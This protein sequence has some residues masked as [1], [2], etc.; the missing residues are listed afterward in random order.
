M[1]FDVFRLPWTDLFLAQCDVVKSMLE[2]SDRVCLIVSFLIV[3]IIE[4]VH[5]VLTILCLKLVEEDILVSLFSRCL[6]WK[7]LLIV[8]HGSSIFVWTYESG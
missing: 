8:W 1:A 4:R 2:P 6:R 3:V 5:M 7:V